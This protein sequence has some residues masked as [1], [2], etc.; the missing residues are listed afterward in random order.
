MGAGRFHYGPGLRAGASVKFMPH[1]YSRERH[2]RQPLSR[3]GRPGELTM[4]YS[5]GDQSRRFS[6]GFTLKSRL[7]M[8]REFPRNEG[9]RRD[10]LRDHQIKEE[11]SSSSLEETRWKR[12][13]FFVVETEALGETYYKPLGTVSQLFKIRVSFFA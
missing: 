3:G 4:H 10:E 1:I 13:D 7:A 6:A 12:F 8:E 9:C 11:N 2:S 5:S